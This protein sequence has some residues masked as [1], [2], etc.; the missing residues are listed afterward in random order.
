MTFFTRMRYNSIPFIFALTFP[1]FACK[2]NLEKNSSHKEV[3]DSNII[4]GKLLAATYCQSCH[5]LPDPSLLDTKSWENGVLPVMGPRLGIFSH[6]S[7]TYPSARHDMD[8]PGD[9]YPSKPLMKPED[10][11]YIIDYYAS[12]SP[13]TLSPPTRKYSVAENNN[14]FEVK[15]L[16]LPSVPTTCFVKLDT[17]GLP[18]QLLM[19][20]MV[21]EKIYRFDNH[22]SLLD[23][24]KT[25]SPVVDIELHDTFLITCNIGVINPNNGKYG[26]GRRVNIGANRK[27]AEDTTLRFAGLRRPVQISS[28]DLNNDGKTDYL[29]CEFGHLTGALSWME[30]KGDNK[31]ERHVLMASPG[32]I[33]A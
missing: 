25:I 14:L 6:G 30:N 21:G 28:A 7:R 2:N 16:R 22:L 19:A 1:F 8:L 10:W 15:E 32:A 17:T 24:F 33:K 11:Q 5:M 4:K 9:F 26:T 18:H 20:D 12:I 31:Y 29:V 23:T 27:M 3:P 13:D